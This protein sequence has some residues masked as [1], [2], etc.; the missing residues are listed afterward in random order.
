[1]PVATGFQPSGSGVGVVS[2]ESDDYDMDSED[3]GSQ[4]LPGNAVEESQSLSQQA[5]SG[6]A[7]GPSSLPLSDSRAESPGS[8]DTPSLSISFQEATTVIG[9][10]LV[11]DIS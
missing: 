4:Q 2:I 6:Y 1:M 7:S 9:N 5:D 11:L 3:A 10:C 8:H